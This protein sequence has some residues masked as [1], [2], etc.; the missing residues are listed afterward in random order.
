MKRI[1]K[2]HVNVGTIGHIDHGKT[3]LT[4][5]ITELL[6]KRGLARA[7]SYDEV[8]RASEKEGRR[9]PGKIITIA[10]AHV[11]YET[12]TRAYA[13]VDCPGHVD[14]IKNMITGAAQMDGAILVVSAADGPMPQTREH[15]LLARQVQVPAIVVF[16]NKVDLVE[17]PEIVEIVELEI[18]DLLTKY[19][20]PGGEVPVV[21]GSALRAR[22]CG[23]A[24]ASCAACGPILRLLEALDRYVPVP[25]RPVERPFLL[26]VERAYSIK[27]RGTVGTGRVESG[28]LHPGDAVEIVGLR[29]G[30]RP[31]VVTSIERFN[32][33]LDEARA[34]DNVGVLLRGVTFEELERGMVIAAPGTVTP[35]EAFEAEVYCLSKD[36]GGRKTPV[37]TGYTPQFYFRTTDVPGVLELPEG[38]EMVMPGETASLRVKLGKPIAVEPGLRFAIREGGRTVGRGIVSK[39]D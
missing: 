30:R 16:L 21:R 35:R 31:S 28:V 8:A 24:E 22:E 17:E 1:E 29:P 5:V 14:Y 18:R 15:V 26:Q 25:P 27:G 38:I 12:E 20:F 37:F 11:P 23:C 4:S 13:H 33:L 9:D 10:A 34:G 6:A 19:E 32:G 7:A 36:E 39:V 2:P 3:T